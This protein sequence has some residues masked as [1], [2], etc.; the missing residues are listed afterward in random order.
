M[1]GKSKVYSV[2]VVISPSGMQYVGYTSMTIKERWR[3]HK[4]RAF[5]GEAVGHPFYDEIRRFNGEGFVLKKL[6]WSNE[7]LEAMQMEEEFINDIPAGLAMNISNGGLHD[8]KEG[9]A[10]AWKKINATPES[11][12]A[13]LQKLSDVKKGNDWTDYEKLAE[14][15]AQWRK[16]HPREA[17]KMAY[18]AIRCADKALGNPPPSHCKVDERPL[19][20]RLMHKYKLN[21]IRRQN[22]T[23]AW[24]RYSEE[25]RAVIAKKISEGQ[26]AQ[27]QNKPQEEIDASCA[28]A[29]NYIDR[30]TQ[31]PAASKGLK[32]WWAELKK[33]PKRYAEYMAKRTTGL[34]RT[35]AQKKA[36]TE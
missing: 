36:V 14:Y 32:N 19:K 16:E 6:A 31:A 22:T 23:A 1:E 7:R 35:L 18:R 10:Q 24:S 34:Q 29:R 11:R 12:T 27:Y 3:H 20:E 13:Y 4:R 15:G 30:S 5:A 28:N 25:Q 2:Y 26:K 17:Y 8:A 21:E 33:D 9:S